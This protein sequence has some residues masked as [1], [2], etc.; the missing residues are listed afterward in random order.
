MGGLPIWRMASDCKSDWRKS[1]GGSNPSPPTTF[2]TLAQLEERCLYTADAIGSNPISPT[3]FMH[4][5]G[6]PYAWKSCVMQ[7][8]NLRCYVCSFQP[9]LEHKVRNQFWHTSHISARSSMDRTKG[10]YPLLCEFES[11]RADQ[12]RKLTIVRLAGY[13]CTV[14]HSLYECVYVATHS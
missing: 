8:R 6:Y 7:L 9:W 5:N 4:E 12:I 2:G 14:G 10:F 3:N 1:R 13:L 11:C